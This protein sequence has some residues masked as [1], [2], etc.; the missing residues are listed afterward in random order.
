MPVA[1]CPSRPGRSQ[2]CPEGLSGDLPPA[3]GMPVRRHDGRLMMTTER[4]VP[5]MGTG[6]GAGGGQTRSPGRSA[7]A[8]ADLDPGYFAFVMATGTIS[9]GMFL[10]GPSWLSRALLVVASI[11]LVLLGA[12]LVIR[13]A[14]FRSS[15]AADIQAPERVFGFFTIVAGIDVLG[16]RLAAA[17]HPLAT[18]ILAALAAAAWLALTYGVPAS[19]LLTRERASVLR[20][21]NGTWLLWVV[22]TQSLSVVAASLAGVWPSQSGLLAPAA[23]GLWSVGLVLYLL[24]VSLILLRWLTVAVSPQ[25]LGPPYWI[26]MGAT[27]ITVLAGAGILNL[28]AALPVTRATAGFV[29]GFSFALWAFGTW[30]IPLLIVLGL[31]RHVRRRWPLSYEPALWSVVFPLGMYSVASLSLG[32]VAQLGFMEPLSRFMLWVAFA[33]WAAVTVAFLARLARRPGEPASGAPA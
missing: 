28:P 18:A 24:L 5:A 17:G 13:L 6:T 26:L 15:L 33:A 23:V 1:P 19:L 9:A 31:W 21:V 8:I 2:A 32:K 22:G 30:W 20:D 29:Q 12:A 4:M 11:G 7:T 10:L 14:I 16:V 27:A 25:T 3:A